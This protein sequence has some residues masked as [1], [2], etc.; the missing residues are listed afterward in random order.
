MMGR[1]K[2]AVLPL[3]VSALARMSRPSRAGGME[4][5]WMGVG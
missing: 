5:V 1:R 2:A 4:S 3:P